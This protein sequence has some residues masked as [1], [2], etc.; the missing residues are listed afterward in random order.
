MKIGTYTK[1]VICYHLVR[2][3]LKTESG[4]AKEIY[5]PLMYLFAL[6]FSKIDREFKNER[7]QL[8]ID[9]ERMRIGK[10]RCLECGG[11]D[12]Y[13]WKAIDSTIARNELRV[14]EAN[15][16]HLG[17]L[18]L[19]TAIIFFTYSYFFPWS[20]EPKEDCNEQK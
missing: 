20:Q 7:K 8:L 16:L 4:R 1:T 12:D 5:K 17:R 14:A 15:R 18:T 9:K 6:P 11:W 2:D 13:I 3:Y 19:R 10:E